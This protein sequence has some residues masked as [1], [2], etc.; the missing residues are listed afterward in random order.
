M[1]SNRPTHS[2]VERT[3]RA[4]AHDQD[5]RDLAAAERL[6]SNILRQQRPGTIRVE[7]RLSDNPMG[8]AKNIYFPRSTTLCHI[9]ELINIEI[10]NNGSHNNDQINLRLDVP[11][12]QIGDLFVAWVA[13]QETT[14]GSTL[15]NGLDQAIDNLYEDFT[16]TVADRVEFID[17]CWTLGQRLEA[18]PFLNYLISKV[19]FIPTRE[20]PEVLVQYV[21]AMIDRELLGHPVFRALCDRIAFA[22]VNDPDTFPDLPSADDLNNLLM[23]AG[24]TLL[25]ETDTLLRE[26]AASFTYFQHWLGTGVEYEFNVLLCGRYNAQLGRPESSPSR[27]LN[28]ADYGKIYGNPEWRKTSGPR[29]TL[30]GEME[31]EVH[32]A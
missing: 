1:S 29:W 25:A 22:A 3:R 18:T 26:Y 5:T 19:G 28:E 9:S 21:G 24:E 16:A 14:A 15:R 32:I 11:R 6:L 4:A 20:K 8:A 12:R 2:W 7:V 10:S 17:L 23:G 30:D 13:R 31:V 27:S